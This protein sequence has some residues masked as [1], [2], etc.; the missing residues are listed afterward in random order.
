M[1]LSLVYLRE[2]TSQHYSLLYTED[3]GIKTSKERLAQWGAI[4]NL[5]IKV[6]CT[7]T[8]AVS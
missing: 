7:K 1:V 2:T 5:E 4:H 8:E 3:T 6:S